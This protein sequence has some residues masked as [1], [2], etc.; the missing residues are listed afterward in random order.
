MSDNAFQRLAGSFFA[1]IMR[2]PFYISIYILIGW[3]LCASAEGFQQPTPKE[4]DISDVYSGLQQQSQHASH[5]LE[6]PWWQRHVYESQRKEASAAAAKIDT[7]LFLALRTSKQIQI[8]SINPIIQ[9]TA[10][11]EQDAAF[12]W[13]NY[14]NTTWNDISEPVGNTLT[15]GGNG[16]YLSDHVIQASAG[17]RRVNR[18]GGQ[19]DV[20]QNF[21]WRHSNSTFLI[22]NNQATGRFTISYTHPLR[23]GRGLMYNTSLVMLAK[24]N[25]ETAYDQFTAELQ[26]HLLEV[27]RSYWYL[28][29]ER[30][31]LAQRV[32]L[33]LKTKELV[34]VLETRQKI[35]AKRTQLITASAALENRRADLIRAQTSVKNAETQLRGLINARELG[36]AD[37]VEIIPIEPPI[38]HPVETDLQTEVE[39]AFQSR[40]EAR[41]ALRQVKAGAVR[42][43]VAN[44]EILPILNLVTETYLSGLR[45]NSNFGGSF[46]DQFSRGAPSYSIGVQYEIPYGNRRAYAQLTRRQLELRQLKL[47]YEQSLEDIR[48]EVDIA[49][50]ELRT[51]YQ[52]IGAKYRA[53]QAANAE[54]ETIEVRWSRMV[55]GNGQSGLNLESLIRAQ[56]RVTDAE[57]EYASAVLTYNLAT[58][59]LKK[60]NG[61]FLQSE[62][63][64]IDRIDTPEGPQ[65]NLGKGTQQAICLEE[66]DTTAPVDPL[67]TFEN[68]EFQPLL[69]PPQEATPIDTEILPLELGLE[70]QSEIRIANNGHPASQRFIYDEPKKVSGVDNATPPVPPGSLNKA[71][72]QTKPASARRPVPLIETSPPTDRSARVARSPNNLLETLLPLSPTATPPTH[73]S[74]PSVEPTHTPAPRKVLSKN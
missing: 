4:F 10:I 74:T 46:G 6:S 57:F 19:L 7:L 65:Y 39:T 22:P 50:R 60:A 1:N 59:N 58:V 64:T 34:S 27:V 70:P 48:V 8:A 18:Q 14:L 66:L 3:I 72:Q 52:E 36:T 26:N 25:S 33:Y 68:Q 71:S 62:T 40:P 56:E 12:D 21:G 37:S 41:A 42:L 31:V 38:T 55:D 2:Q 43:D 16:N 24:V 63:I 45:G 54:A 20:N 5:P 67:D 51:A 47:L 53:L 29:L 15:I 44:H 23:R 28:Y 35:D 13:T 30:S 11:T 32:R 61:T 73:K 69:I 9:E 49:I 17:A